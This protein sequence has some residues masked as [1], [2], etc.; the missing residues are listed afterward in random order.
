MQRGQGTGDLPP[1][2][3]SLKRYEEAR[4]LLTAFSAV[5]H[6]QHADAPRPGVLISSA[7]EHGYTSSV[8]SSLAHPATN[9][10]LRCPNVSSSFLM[11]A[12][13]E[14]SPPPLLEDETRSK[15]G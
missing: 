3:R 7:I 10:L 15:L 1:Q 5:R 9:L 2:L 14:V 11:R 6:L 4:L 12:G 8:P 13:P